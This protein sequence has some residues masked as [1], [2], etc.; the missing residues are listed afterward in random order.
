MPRAQFYDGWVDGAD[1]ECT[2]LVDLEGTV[3][4]AGGHGKA[5][6]GYGGGG[7]VDQPGRVW[8]SGI[9]PLRDGTTVYV[10]VEGSDGF[11]AMP[12]TDFFI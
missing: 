6:H 5:V 3:I 7:A 9:G 8:F 2:L 12:E 1:I 4:G 11:V 10:K